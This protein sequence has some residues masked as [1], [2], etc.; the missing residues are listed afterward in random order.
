MTLESTDGGISLNAWVHV[1]PLQRARNASFGM[2]PSNALA[3]IN[4]RARQDINK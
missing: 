1:S 3:A 4:L 2:T